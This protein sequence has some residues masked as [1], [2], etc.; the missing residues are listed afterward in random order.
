LV[1]FGAYRGGVLR[2][3]EFGVMVGNVYSSYSGYREET[4]AGAAQLVLTGQ[5]LRDHGFA[6]WDL[7]MTMSY[8][9]DLGARDVTLSEFMPKWRAATEGAIRAV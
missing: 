8:K 1:S 4:G 7:G 2:A 6:F 3:G 5:Y 9:N